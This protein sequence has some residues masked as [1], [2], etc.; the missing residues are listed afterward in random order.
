VAQPLPKPSEPDLDEP[1][2]DPTARAR[3]YRQARLRRYARVERDRAQKY[4]GVRFWTVLLALLAASAFVI[5]T[6]WRE[7]ERLFGL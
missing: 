5:L 2:V 6:A 4:A 3:A 7:V 1:P